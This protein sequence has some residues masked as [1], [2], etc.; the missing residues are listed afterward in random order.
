M[1]RGGAYVSLISCWRKKRS[2]IPLA[3]NLIQVDSS[4]IAQLTF[5]NSLMTIDE[6]Q[7]SSLSPTNTTI[8]IRSQSEECH[9]TLRMNNT[10]LSIVEQRELYDK[11]SAYKF[12]KEPTTPKLAG[13]SPLS[14]PAT[15]SGSFSVPA[16]PARGSFNNS[17]RPSHRRSTA[18]S[19]SSNDSIF[20]TMGSRTSG[21]S[22]VLLCE[23]SLPATSVKFGTK[24]MTR[25]RQ[26]KEIAQ[27]PIID[28][29]AAALPLTP[30]MKY[31]QLST[32]LE[33]DETEF[34]ED[35]DEDCGGENSDE[36]IDMV[37]FLRESAS[38]RAMSVSEHYDPLDYVK[39]Y[40][41]LDVRSVSGH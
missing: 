14:A 21:E 16:S 32:P 1:A 8:D 5:R 24:E 28:L 31:T 41:A 13:G 9:T 40:G 36:S 20:D 10:K 17:L 26:A 39:L 30:K 12:P 27:A 7:G 35:C 25:K 34:H 38:T 4:T 15:L 22:P 6:N 11:L 18:M 23:Q 2:L 37:D 33:D 3:E 29:D 19:M